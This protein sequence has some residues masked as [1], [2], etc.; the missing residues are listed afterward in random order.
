MLELL[1]PAVDAT[2]E[3]FLPARSCA[4]L[5]VKF[6]SPPIACIRTKAPRLGGPWRGGRPWEALERIPGAPGTRSTG[7]NSRQVL[8]ELASYSSGTPPAAM[9]ALI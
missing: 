1:H 4:G 7:Y 8:A 5:S 6:C 9:V 3:L 2:I